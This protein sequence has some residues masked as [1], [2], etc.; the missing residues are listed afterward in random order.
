MMAVHD[1]WLNQMKNP[2]QA[3]E[4]QQGTLRSDCYCSRCVLQHT[5]MMI[6]SELL[7]CASDLAVS[8]AAAAT[9]ITAKRAK[10]ARLQLT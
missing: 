3:A 9:M 5:V 1:V 6:V 10:P 8:A 2:V 4:S 7:L